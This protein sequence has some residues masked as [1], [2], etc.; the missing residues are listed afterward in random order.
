MD[1]HY[2]PRPLNLELPSQVLGVG[3]LVP[4]TPSGKTRKRLKDTADKYCSNS[5]SRLPCRRCRLRRQVLANLCLLHYGCALHRHTPQ[6]VRDPPYVCSC[7][8][9]KFMP[10]SCPCRNL[11]GPP[12]VCLTELRKSLIFPSM[13]WS[14][15]NP[16]RLS[17]RKE[18]SK[19][20]PC[21]GSPA[22][23]GG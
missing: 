20:V 17:D 11:V 9:K 18:I 8:T 22:S 19:Q 7:S 23:V 21:L 12:R 2:L 15:V 6:R 10:L 3:T 1:C 16:G 5:I 13:D 4:V 14:L